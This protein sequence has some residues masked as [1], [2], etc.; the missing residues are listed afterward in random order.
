MYSSRLPLCLGAL[1][2]N[3]WSLEISPLLLLSQT[4]EAEPLYGETARGSPN[5][6][7]STWNAPPSGSLR[8]ITTHPELSQAP[9][10]MQLL[11][12]SATCFHSWFERVALERPT[13]RTAPRSAI[14]PCYFSSDLYE[15]SV[16]SSCSSQ[17][18]ASM[19][20]LDMVTL[21]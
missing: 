19:C 7:P 21:L 18:T 9:G 1:R 3:D 4:Y 6:P 2:H 14:D 5:I 11:L 12:D 16:A 15:R 13:P 20:F 17:S 10:L 8:I